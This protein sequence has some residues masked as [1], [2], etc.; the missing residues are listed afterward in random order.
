MEAYMNTVYPLTLYYDSSCPL[1]NQEMTRLK[2][3]DQA[4]N[5]KL[6]DCS[7]ADYAA[8]AGAPERQKMMQLLHA[9]TADGMW[10]VGV[11]AFRLAYAGAGF[12]FV[13]DWLDRPYIK[14][15]MNR[16]YPLIARNRYLIPGW[17]AKIWFNW[18]A[19]HAQRRSRSCAKGQCEI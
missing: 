18:L 10:V 13:A 8:P 9:Q 4:D 16:L 5:L 15:A 2:Q 19:I 1:C 11:P 7:A 17:F 3:H 12:H 6:V 14:Q